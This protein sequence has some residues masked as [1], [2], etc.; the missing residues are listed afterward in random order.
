MKDLEN[1]SV[2]AIGSILQTAVGFLLLPIYIKYLSPAEYGII[3]VIWTVS[4]ILAVVTNLASGSGFFR[5]YFESAGQESEEKG[6]KRLFTTTLIWHLATA[7]LAFIF[8]VFTAKYLSLFFFKSDAYRLSILLAGLF[9]FISP[10]RELFFLTLRLRQL[11]KK[12]VI[13]SLFYSIVSFSSKFIYIAILDEGVNGFWLAHVISE[14]LTAGIIFYHGRI[15][16]L[17]GKPKLSLLKSVLRVGFPYTPST[18]GSWI[19]KSSDK[20]F[21][22]F[23]AGPTVVGIYTLATR[24]ASLFEVI[25]NTPVTLWCGPFAL[26]KAAKEGIE[27]F[28]R[29]NKA[30]LYAFSVVGLLASVLISLLGLIVAVLPGHPEYKYAIFLIPFC[31][32][33]H[34]LYLLM[35]PP[36]LQ[37]LQAKKTA[38]AGWG[39]L[40]AALVSLVLNIFL[41]PLIGVWGAI[42]SNIIAYFSWFIVYYIGGQRSLYI[43]YEWSLIGKNFCILLLYKMTLVVTFL[44]NK[45][46]YIPILALDSIAAVIVL[47]TFNYKFFISSLSGGTTIIRNLIRGI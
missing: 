29:T 12:F 13:Y 43:D 6:E 2:Y 10:L 42:I 32:L 34:L 4:S 27:P 24:M 46:L 17:L 25:L 31:M 11:A 30:F 28:K 16:S 1:F 26:E 23:F 41:I 3:S 14:I 38:Y 40:V 39:G 47:T 19:V 21:L 18:L 37:F 9:I 36:A 22:N 7:L 5:L 15:I 45:D 35:H 33:P 20:L 8:A 44:L